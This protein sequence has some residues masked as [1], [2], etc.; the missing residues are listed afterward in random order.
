MNYFIISI[1]LSFSILTNTYIQE[2]H[3]QVGNI[4]KNQETEI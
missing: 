3:C 1:L 4:P 2:G